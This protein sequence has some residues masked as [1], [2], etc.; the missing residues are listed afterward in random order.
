M[1]D[2]LSRAALAPVNYAKEVK[3]LKIPDVTMKG[4]PMYPAFPITLLGSLLS[5]LALAIY[6]I[7][8][9]FESDQS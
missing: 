5:L 1:G 8:Y 2:C 9:F 6:M 7:V 3:A 4:T